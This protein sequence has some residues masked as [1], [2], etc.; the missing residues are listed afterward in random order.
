MK[1][2]VVTPMNQDCMSASFLSAA[3]ERALDMLARKQT[4]D[5]DET[6]LLRALQQTRG[7]PSRPLRPVEYVV[8]VLLM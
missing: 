6:D 8:T 3:T 2:G 5:D 7:L 4:L 1:T